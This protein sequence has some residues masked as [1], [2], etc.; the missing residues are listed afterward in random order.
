MKTIRAFNQDHNI[1]K[2]YDFAICLSKTK[3]TDIYSDKYEEIPIEF[4][5]KIYDVKCIESASNSIIF[6]IS[7]NSSYLFIN[8]FPWEF[9][10]PTDI[11][12]ASLE[13]IEEIIVQATNKRLELFETY[14]V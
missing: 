9:G 4:G 3:A 14:Y 11:E 8:S 13:K 10:L 5:Q 6:S 2:E 7:P 12:L 1:L